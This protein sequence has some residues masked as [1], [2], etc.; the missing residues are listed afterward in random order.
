MK[1]IDSEY[2]LHA[3]ENKKLVAGALKR[4]HVLPKYSE[5]DDLLAEGIIT[6]AEMLAKHAGCKE[7][8]EIDKL[9]F[10]KIVWTT[11]DRLRKLAKKDDSLITIDQAFNLYERRADLD[12]LIEIRTL[13]DQLDKTEL[14]ILTEHLIKQHTL[15]ELARIT[16]LSR[17]KLTRAK[18]KLMQKMKQLVD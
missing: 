9:A 10:N 12:L 15:V 11:I 7:I 4:C 6:Y 1:T 14:M 17:T 16:G 5:Y 13:A 8:A 18:R 3:W 2:F